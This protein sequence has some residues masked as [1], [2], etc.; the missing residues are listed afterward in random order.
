MSSCSFMSPKICEERY[1]EKNM[2]EEEPECMLCVY[3]LCTA[4]YYD[5]NELNETILR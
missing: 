2:A 3:P 4:S 5:T 1:D